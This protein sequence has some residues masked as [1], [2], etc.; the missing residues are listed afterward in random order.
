MSSPIHGIRCATVLLEESNV[1]TSVGIG[2]TPLTHTLY[3]SPS[4][5]QLDILLALTNPYSASLCLQLIRTIITCL[6]ALSCLQTKNITRL[7][8]QLDVISNVLCALNY[9]QRPLMYSRFFW[10]Y[11]VSDT[12]SQPMDLVTNNVV[13]P[14]KQTS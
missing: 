9:E 4:H 5:R 10:P 7:D 12:E 11:L 14:L 1:L 2:L 13:I 6:S 3:M 8:R